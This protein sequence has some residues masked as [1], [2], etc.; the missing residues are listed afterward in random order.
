MVNPK[1]DQGTNN[2]SGATGWTF[3][4]KADHIGW[5]NETQQSGSDYAYEYWKATVFD[6]NQTIVGLPEGFYR[7]SCQALYRP[8]NNTDEVA[9]IYAADPDNARDMAFYAN[10]KSVRMASVYDY[11]QSEATGANGEGSCT[12]NGETVYIPNTMISAGAYFQLGYYTNSLI[13]KVAKDEPLKVGLKL[14]GNIV[15]A[16]WCVFDNFK[17]EAL[18]NDPNTAVSN[19]MSQAGASEIFNLNGM[20]QNRLQKGVNIVRKADGAVVK[21][22]VK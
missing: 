18:G 21:V 6:M 3:D 9:A 13:V 20:K 8:G 4:W 14:D 22:L 15:D 1:F 7:V 10:S 5:N 19:I 2:K 12:L 16:N 17:V 11:A